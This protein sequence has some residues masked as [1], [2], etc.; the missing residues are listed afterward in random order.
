MMTG[1][2]FSGIG[3]VGVVTPAQALT[4]NFTSADTALQAA[5]DGLGTSGSPQTL[6]ANGFKAAGN[7]WG[8]I[9]T[10]N[11]TVNINVNFTALAPGILGST[12]STRQ[13][14][15]YSQVYNA[16]KNDS[17]LSADDNKAIGSLSSNPVLSRLINYTADNSNGS[18]S[19]TPDLYSAGPDTN[20]NYP[21]VMELTNA[22]AK[23]LGLATTGSSDASISFSSTFTFDFN[24]ADGINN[25]SNFDFVGLA[26]HEIGHSLGFVSGV[27]ILD[28]NINNPSG[29]FNASQFRFVRPLDL[30]RYSTLSTSNNAIDWTADTRDKYFSLDGGANSIASFSTGQFFGDGQQA[31]H[32]KD[33]FGLG[34]MDPTFT[35]G[36]LGIISQNDI[37]AFDVIGWN[38]ADAA[39]AVPEPANFIGTFIFA[40][41]GAKM[42]IKRRKKLLE[43]VEKSTVR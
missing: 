42:V 35:N 34:I 8:A 13:N 7:R 9:F 17:N 4:F 15:S 6:A 25:P 36:E 39:T 30:F 16:L 26:T 12:S 37:R 21:L 18:A 29:P 11:V 43:S 41:F 28:S 19:A 10:D 20:G 3:I 24:P 23:A 2:A 33:N 40:A 27:D 32:W 5:I 22:N 38:R 31:S 14:F 1:I